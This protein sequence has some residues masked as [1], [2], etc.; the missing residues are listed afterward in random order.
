[1]S[2]HNQTAA[3]RPWQP[4]QPYPPQQLDLATAARIA[5]WA[6]RCWTREDMAYVR[7]CGE[8]LIEQLIATGAEHNPYLTLQH[9]HGWPQDIWV[10]EH[11][12]EHGYAWDGQRFTRTPEAALLSQC[13]AC[14]ICTKRPVCGWVINAPCSDCPYPGLTNQGGGPC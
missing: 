8:P 9:V 10:P 3:T 11:L 6:A 2:A 7:Q 14:A 13:R 1:M 12:S 5:R 4:T